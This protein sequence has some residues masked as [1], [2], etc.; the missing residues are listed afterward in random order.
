MWRTDQH[1]RRRRRTLTQRLDAH[2]RTF[3]ALIGRID[4]NDQVDGDYATALTEL[5]GR[6]A[7]LEALVQRLAAQARFHQLARL[8]EQRNLTLLR[9]GQLPADGTTTSVSGATT[10]ASTAPAAA[11]QG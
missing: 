9:L 6:V 8:V 10:E 1:R 4:L 11:P 2:A 5:E 7:D 3:T